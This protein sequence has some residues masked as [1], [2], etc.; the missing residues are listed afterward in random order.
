VRL[1]LRLRLSMLLPMLIITVFGI[2]SLILTVFA[3]RSSVRLRITIQVLVLLPSMCA[4]LLA[5][6]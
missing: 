3:V 5:T 1:L 4:S 2:R 6:H